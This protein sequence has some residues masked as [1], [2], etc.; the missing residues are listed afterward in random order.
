MPLDVI[1]LQTFK[2]VLNE[3]ERPVTILK[4][5]GFT[6]D[7]KLG[8]ELFDAGMVDLPKDTP[9][10]EDKNALEV[11][12]ER[13]FE[14]LL[15]SLPDPDSMTLAELKQFAAESDIDISGGTKKAEIVD[16]IKTA[17]IQGE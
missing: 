17:L 8:E 14:E 1:A 15:N 6:V 9:F 16:I 4:G 2:I 5:K 13:E 11:A 3:G 7:D 10:L 12:Q